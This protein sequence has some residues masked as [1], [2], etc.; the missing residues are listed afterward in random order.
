MRVF[1]P[2]RQKYYRL[3][4][5]KKINENRKETL[6]SLPYTPK[7]FHYSNKPTE[8]KRIKRGNIIQFKHVGYIP[9]NKKK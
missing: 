7:Q 8:K 9:K 2:H 4:I 3:S 5:I 1:L 6:F